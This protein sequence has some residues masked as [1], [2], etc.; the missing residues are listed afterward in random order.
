MLDELPFKSQRNSQAVTVGPLACLSD[1]PG[2][3]WPG[4]HK[5]P[6]LD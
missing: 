6:P 5:H 2:M 3:N 4:L 1:L